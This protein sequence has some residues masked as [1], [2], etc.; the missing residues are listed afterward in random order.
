MRNF[1]KAFLTGNLGADPKKIENQKWLFRLFVS[2][3]NISYKDKQGHIQTITN[4]FDL[5]ANGKTADYILN[6]FKKGQH[7]LIEAELYSK[8]EKNIPGNIIGLKVLTIQN[9]SP[10]SKNKEPVDKDS[11]S[12]ESF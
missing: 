4:W 10:I 8:N 3:N 11:E 12:E 5:S 2:R 1:R 7:V 9:L 6:Y